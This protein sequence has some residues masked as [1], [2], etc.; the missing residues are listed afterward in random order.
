MNSVVP[1]PC[2][3]GP[4]VSC[5]LFCA[6]INGGSVTYSTDREDGIS[7]MFTT[8]LLCADGFSNDLYSHGTASN[9]Q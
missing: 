3:S 1:S 9:F 2:E 8:S 7:K 5:G 4:Y 6:V